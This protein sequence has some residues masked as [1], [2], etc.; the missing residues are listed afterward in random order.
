MNGILEI[1]LEIGKPAAEEALRRLVSELGQARHHGYRAVKIIHG[2]GSSGKGGRIRTVCRQYLLQEAAEDRLRAVLPGEDFTIFSED[3]RRAFS[4]CDGLRRD[5]DLENSNR[6]VT[7][8]V[9]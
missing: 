5:R 7:L 8:V 2:Y 4:L 3:T 6:G 9:L 1:N